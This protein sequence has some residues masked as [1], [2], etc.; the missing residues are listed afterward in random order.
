MHAWIV[1]I[2][3]T[4]SGNLYTGIT[5]DLKRRFE[6]HEQQKG[7]ARFFRIS[8]PEKVVYK[9]TFPNR[10][11]ASKREYEIK[12][13]TRLE[14]LGLIKIKLPEKDQD[15]LTECRVEAYRASGSGGQ[16]VNVTDSAVRLTHL[17]TG[18]AVTSQ[19]E[20]SQHLNKQE[21]LEK[22]REKVTQLNYR[23]P[24][25]KAT[26]VPYSV[27]KKDQTKKMKE[28]QKKRLRRPPREE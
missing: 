7:G 16:H 13:M 11:E 27:K 23:K 12:Q 26:C 5:N 17:P 10:S 2:I 9:E 6:S 8:K 14:K 28:S 18:I 4:E 20:R 21:C 15:L 3:Q 1:Y 24:R 25:R 19:K 22:L